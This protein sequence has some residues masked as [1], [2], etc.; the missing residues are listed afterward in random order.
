MIEV[1]AMI[2]N[3]T[4]FANIRACLAMFRIKTAEG[5]QYRLANLANASVGVFWALIDITVY[6]VFYQYAERKDAGIIAGMNINQLVTYVWLAEAILPM[7]VMGVD[8]EIL[9]KITSGDVSVEL[10][11][12]LDLYFQWFSKSAA[13]RLAPLFWR[14]SVILLTG[15]IMPPAYRIS[16]PASFIG[17][18]WMLVSLLA[19]FLLC[20]SYAMLICA[21]RMK[22]TW[23]D[24]ITN[25][26]MLIG[27]I[28][29]GA[30]LPLQLWPEWMQGFLRLQPF[31]GYLD[32]PVR[33]Y[34]GT[35]SPER[36][37]S[38]VS[39]QILWSV[40]F[41]ISGKL[42]MAKRLRTIVIQGG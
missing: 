16:L 18:L 29:S 14:S 32:I 25:M 19:A 28:L 1:S 17:F 20:T 6:L 33:L 21:V 24:G 42:L 40:V 13:A 10:C 4:V 30:Y 11:R 36:A 27:S 12:P 26:M 38:S 35:I 5:F 23:G 9:G 41:I 8:G 15:I 31:A 7:I 22:I 34:I 37:I 39:I 3:S 2:R